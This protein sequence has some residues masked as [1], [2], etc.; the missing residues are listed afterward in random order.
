MVTAAGV[1][2]TIAGQA[3]SIGVLLGDLPG[4]LNAPIGMAVDVSGALYTTCE[5]SVLRI[6]L[7]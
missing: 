4:S 6:Q 5:N 1:V 2:T 3:G 7:P